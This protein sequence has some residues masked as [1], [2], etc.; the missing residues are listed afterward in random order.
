MKS[1]KYAMIQFMKD[2]TRNNGD[3]STLPGIYCSDKIINFYCLTNGIFMIMCEHRREN[4]LI[5]TMYTE[6]MTS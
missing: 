1:V 4:G 2:T 5:W 3:E 6:T